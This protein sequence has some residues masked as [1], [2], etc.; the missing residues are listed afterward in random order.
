[1]TDRVYTI[2]GGPTANT[3]KID[4]FSISP[5]D[6]IPCSIHAVYIGQ[7]SEFGDAQDE[8]LEV[9]LT[10]GGTAM[11]AGSGGSAPTPQPLSSKEQAAGFTARAL[12]TTI[13]TFTSG[14]VVHRDAFNVRAGWQYIPAP[15]DRIVVSQANGG[16]SCS[17][18]AA[19]ADSV[20]WTITA[21]IG[22]MA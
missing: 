1:M 4:F 11:T 16:L 20:T 8:N 12:D 2:N 3:V 10:R 7:T 15:E 9:F 5:A 22:E 14:V 21:Y 19:P 18:N 13:A 17:L 6:D